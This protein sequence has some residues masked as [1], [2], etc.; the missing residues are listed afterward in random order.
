MPVHKGKNEYKRL[1]QPISSLQLNLKRP[2]R[3]PKAIGLIFFVLM[4]ILG[5]II[6]FSKIRPAVCS[7]VI[8]LNTTLIEMDISQIDNIS[9]S[10]NLLDFEFVVDESLDPTKFKIVLIEKNVQNPSDMPHLIIER[11]IEEKLLHIHNIDPENDRHPCRTAAL[12]VH[13]P[14]NWDGSGAYKNYIF[15]NFSIDAVT[16]SNDGLDIGNWTNTKLG[17]KYLWIN[18]E[19]STVT[20]DHIRVAHMRVEGG[21]SINRIECVGDSIREIQIQAYKNDHFI[22][23]VSRCAVDA[24]TSLGSVVLG[25]NSEWTGSFDIESVKGLV[26][27]ERFD[28]YVHLDSRYIH[29][30]HHK[31]GYIRKN[32]VQNIVIH[33][34]G[35]GQVTLFRNDF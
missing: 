33:S 6:L 3:D 13:V 2:A 7:N 28:P 24:S 26:W 32:A 31:R 10:V 30:S 29:N 19:G 4:L 11:N 25:V 8:M 14:S 34:G 35:E 5:F 23:N 22:G 9:I 18:A 27:I 20:G 1:E 16:V 21:V 12:T 17:I 15:R